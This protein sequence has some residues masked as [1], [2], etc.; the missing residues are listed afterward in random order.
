MIKFIGQVCAIVLLIVCSIGQ[1]MAQGASFLEAD[2]AVRAF[3]MKN[4][5]SAID[6]A[7]KATRINDANRESWRVLG[8]S[9][10]EVGDFDLM[11]KAGGALSK[12]VPG[13]R[14]GWYMLSIGHYRK[15]QYAEAITPMQEL[16]RIDPASCASSGINSILATFSQDAVGVKD[17]VFAIDNGVSISLPKSW[18]RDVKVNDSTGNVTAFVTLEQMKSDLDAFSAGLVFNWTRR[19]GETYRLDDKENTAQT[20]ITFWSEIDAKQ[21]AELPLTMWNVT[22]SASVKIGQWSGFTRTVELQ[23][24]DEARPRTA[25][26]T[27]IA[28]PDELIVMTLECGAAEWPVYR[29]RF[30]RSLSTLILP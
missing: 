29:S 9:A 18:Y 3:N 30:R 17:S 16:C 8:Y 5:E 24:R 22:D 15:G 26:Q 28:K 11:I 13:E 21:T 19:M 20:I 12:L 4:F 2:S 27:F 10:R 25:L 7:L 14:H 1:S 23:L 6:W